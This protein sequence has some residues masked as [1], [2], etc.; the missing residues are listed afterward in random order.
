[1]IL[2]HK[3]AQLEE[4]AAEIRRLVANWTGEYQFTLEQV[5]NDM[6]GRSRPANGRPP[7]SPSGQSR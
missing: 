6:I 1:M 3:P 7:A 2:C 5:L 4:V